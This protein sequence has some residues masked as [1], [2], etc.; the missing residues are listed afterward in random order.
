MVMDVWMVVV[1][2]LGIGFGIVGGLLG[3]LAVG[4]AL[5]GGLCESATADEFE[6]EDEARLRECG[7]MAR[8]LRETD[9]KDRP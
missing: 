4:F 2:W 8:G 5:L 3:L 9:R 1:T 6:P 7:E